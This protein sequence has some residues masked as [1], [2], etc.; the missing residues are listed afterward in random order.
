MWRGLA[1]PFLAQ[2]SAFARKRD[3]NPT[4]LAQDLAQSKEQQK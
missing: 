3:Q 4:F 2:N 1:Q